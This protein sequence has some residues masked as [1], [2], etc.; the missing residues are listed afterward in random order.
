[1]CQA[2]SELSACSITFRTMEGTNEGAE[3]LPT[4]RW[5]SSGLP[6]G[7]PEWLVPGKVVN[8]SAAR[9]TNL[10]LPTPPILVSSVSGRNT[11][12]LCDFHSLGVSSLSK[13]R[14]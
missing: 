11:G 4:S 14:P 1:M 13:A 6:L 7:Y 9:K 5:V 8:Q 2:C 12:D 10:C 3:G